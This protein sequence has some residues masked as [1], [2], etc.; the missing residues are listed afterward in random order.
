MSRK[1]PLEELDSRSQSAPFLTQRDKELFEI[2]RNILARVIYKIHF[3]YH[4][5]DLLERLKTLVKLVDEFLML[6]SVSMIP[7]LIE[8]IEKAAERFFQ[9]LSMGLMITQSMTCVGAL[10]RLSE[11]LRRIPV[12]HS[13]VSDRTQFE[14]EFDEGIPVD[15]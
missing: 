7:Q 1:R 14:D 6:V 11:I 8:A 4:R 12:A 15:R 13:K 3:Q 2:D 9:Q 5:I 10:A